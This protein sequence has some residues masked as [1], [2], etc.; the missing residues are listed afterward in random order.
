MDQTRL[1]ASIQSVG[2]LLL[3]HFLSFFYFK[4]F[5]IA[6][7]STHLLQHFFVNEKVQFS[8]SIDNGMLAV[9]LCDLSLLIDHAT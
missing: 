2:P 9:V 3:P 4:L 6:Q 8:P 5:F 1:H 7:N